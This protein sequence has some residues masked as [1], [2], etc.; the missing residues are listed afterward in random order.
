[1]TGANGTEKTTGNDVTAAA[2]AAAAAAGNESEIYDRQ[3]RLWGAEAQSK[4]ASA[5]VLYVNMSG[6]SSEI[7]K[8]LILAGVRCAICD[9]RPYPDA[10][11]DMPSSFLPPSERTPSS[12][13]T[14]SSSS[15]SSEA[16]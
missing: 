8:N 10:V 3:I 4:M 16:P 1:M 7:L 2:A 14:S 12:T 5:K 6:V 13:S 11:L 15:S 9:D